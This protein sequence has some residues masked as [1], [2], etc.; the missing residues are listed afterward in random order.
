MFPLRCA[1]AQYRQNIWAVK[2]HARALATFQIQKYNI[3]NIFGGEAE[4]FW[5]YR[6][7]LLEAVGM[8]CVLCSYIDN[9]L[10]LF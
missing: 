8:K 9:I 7:V 4:R 1:N 2:S 10:N 3:I 6:V 5:V